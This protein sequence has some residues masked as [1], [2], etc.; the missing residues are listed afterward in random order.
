MR[1]SSPELR[2]I[3]G[4]LHRDLRVDA[5]SQ[6][7]DDARLQRMVTGA[8]AGTV[9]LGALWL[10][11]RSSAG[12]KLGAVVVATATATASAATWLATR[13]T[14]EHAQ[15]VTRADEPAAAG[16]AGTAADVAIATPPA[17]LPPVV[18]PA[19]APAPTT[20]AAVAPR[21][22]TRAEPSSAELLTAANAAR[23]D[24]ELERAA[25]LYRAL[26]QRWPDSREAAVGCVALG[27]LQLDRDDAAAAAETFARCVTQH[28]RGAVVEQAW[29]G[30]AEALDALG[31]DASARE[32][33]S[34][35]L[36]RFPDSLFAARARKRLGG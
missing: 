14:A 4:R 16:P 33:W 17:T 18:A 27:R 5:A 32:A 20:T 9:G 10:A 8:V 2:S 30:R 24:R 1:D 36:R 6:P 3:E 34:E 19:P 12:L 23:A 28:P 15:V 22:A 29:V 35:L 7:G 26:Q 25:S 21:A 11:L 13:P 31:H